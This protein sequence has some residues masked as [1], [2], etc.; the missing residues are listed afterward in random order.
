[1][2]YAKSKRKTLFCVFVDFSK[3]YDRVPRNVLFKLLKTAGCGSNMLKT[4]IS[5]YMETSM[6]LKSAI[7]NTKQGVRQ[8][9]P[10]S[11]LLFVFLINEFVKMLKSKCADD[12]YLK[13]LH[14]LILMDD[15][16][17]LATTRSACLQKLDLLNQFCNM[18]GMVINAKKKKFCCYQ[19]YPKRHRTSYLW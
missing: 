19:W 3:A 18:S 12:G 9:S 6:I 4:L 8:G 13:W 15:T 11:C 5:L 14:C 17:I 10:S 2:D 16:V 1:M 7:I